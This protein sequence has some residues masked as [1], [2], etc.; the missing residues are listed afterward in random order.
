[1]QKHIASIPFANTF[2]VYEE[3]PPSLDASV[4]WA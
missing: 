2:L 3:D 1:M 4:D